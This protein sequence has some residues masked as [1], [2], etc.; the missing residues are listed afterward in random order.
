MYQPI[1]PFFKP[2]KTFFSLNTT[3]CQELHQY[4]ILQAQYNILQ[5]QYKIPQA[6]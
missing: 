4:K 3:L 2:N 6:Q 1:T 5:A